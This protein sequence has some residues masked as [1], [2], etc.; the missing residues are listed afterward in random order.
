[1]KVG[2]EVNGIVRV[3]IVQRQKCHYP[4]YLMTEY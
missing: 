2:S 1:M 4:H 3:A